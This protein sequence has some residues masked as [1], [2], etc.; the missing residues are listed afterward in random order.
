MHP[1]MTRIMN[2]L[3]DHNDCVFK[4]CHFFY[5]FAIACLLL[6]AY[7]LVRFV[8]CFLSVTILRNIERMRPSESQPTHTRRKKNHCYLFNSPTAQPF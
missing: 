8:A 2:G 7:L 5:L 3:L 6:L 4:I 1:C